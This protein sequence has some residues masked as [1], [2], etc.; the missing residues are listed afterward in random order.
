MK[1]KVTIAL[2]TLCCSSLTYADS[3]YGYCWGKK[4]GGI[5]CKEVE[6]KTSGFAGRCETW[7]KAHGAYRWG[8]KS[9]STYEA[10]VDSQA[11][12]CDEVLGQQQPVVKEPVV[13]PPKPVI[14]TLPPTVIPV[15]IPIS[16]PIVVAPPVTVFYDYPELQGSWQSTSGHIVLNFESSKNRMVQGEDHDENLDFRYIIMGQ[17]EKKDRAN[18]EL[19]R[20]DRKTGCMT[21]LDGTLVMKSEVAFHLN[22]TMTDGKCDLPIDYKTV[23][24]FTRNLISFSSRR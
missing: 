9:A 20:S 21:K 19:F 23:I 17:F 4:D 18:I 5:F 8:N 24:P 14:P 1:R 11:S 12:F 2:L 10:M 22:I 6:K 3:W 13:L 7:A 16:K 15:P